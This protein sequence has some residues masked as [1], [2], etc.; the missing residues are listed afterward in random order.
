MNSA[1]SGDMNNYYIYITEGVPK[2]YTHFK[3]EKNCIKIVMVLRS[4]ND[5]RASAIFFDCPACRVVTLAF[6]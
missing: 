3:K 1:P 2:I 6:I 4:S 5:N